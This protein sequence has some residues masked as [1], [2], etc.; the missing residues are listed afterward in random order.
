MRLARIFL[1]LSALIAAACHSPPAPAPAAWSGPPPS[2]RLARGVDLPTDASDVL[3]ELKASG[4]DFVARYYR[5]PGSRWPALSAG[6]AQQLSAMGVKIVAV[7]E[8]HSHKAAHF[9][10]ASGY[11]DGLNAYGQARAIGQPPGSAV[12]FAVDYNAP[13]RD[14]GTVA[15]YFRGA[16]DA[17]AA[18]GGGLS[19]YT[20]GVYGSGAVCDALKGSSLARFCWLSNAIAWRGSIGYQG[21]DIRQGGRLPLLSF[22]HDSNEARDESGAFR[23]AAVAPAPVSQALPTRPLF[24]TAGFP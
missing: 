15:A 14:F 9:S 1:V 7:W 23:L 20:V 18:A 4:V 10:Y 8:S 3:A 13:S 11:S 6:E 17:F 12:Y 21:W 24:A 16:A 22:D 2:A 5:E 19:D